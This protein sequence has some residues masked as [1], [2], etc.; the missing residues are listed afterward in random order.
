MSLAPVKIKAYI[1]LPLELIFGNEL[2][3]KKTALIVWIWG[4]N[5]NIHV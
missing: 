4:H 1:N 3:S 5:L 2:I